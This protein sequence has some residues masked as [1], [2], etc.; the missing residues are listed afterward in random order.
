MRRYTYDLQWLEEVFLPYYLDGWEKRLH[1]KPKGQQER[2][3]SMRTSI[4]TS[5]LSEARLCMIMKN[6]LGHRHMY[7]HHMYVAEKMTTIYCMSPYEILHMRYIASVWMCIYIPHFKRRL[8][9]SFC[10]QCAFNVL[11]DDGTFTG[12]KKKTRIFWCF[13]M[14]GLLAWN[15]VLRWHTSQIYM[16]TATSPDLKKKILRLNSI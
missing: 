10:V 4:R 3:Q 1:R 7:V 16:M 14:I 9:F 6:L 11:H 2:I 12:L 8:C 15:V 13:F 5:S